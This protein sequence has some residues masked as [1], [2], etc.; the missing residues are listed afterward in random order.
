MLQ[1][2]CF[3]VIIERLFRCLLFLIY[4]FGIY[5][6]SCKL[7]SFSDKF[8]IVFSPCLIVKK[9]AR[10]GVLAYLVGL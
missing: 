7:G 6:L 8:F 5:T 10:K 2:M 3:V 4:Y 1:L 9:L